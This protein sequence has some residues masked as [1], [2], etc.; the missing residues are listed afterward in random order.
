MERIPNLLMAPRILRWFPDVDLWFR[1]N[2]RFF[3]IYL[4]FEHAP[5]LGVILHA[6][7]YNFIMFVGNAVTR[8]SLRTLRFLYMQGTIDGTSY[9][10]ISRTCHNTGVVM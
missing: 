1:R 9:M 7:R 4:V 5:L 2:Y 3:F 6:V 10:I 8:L